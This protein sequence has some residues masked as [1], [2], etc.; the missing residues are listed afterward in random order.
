[1]SLDELFRRLP[2]VKHSTR[3][4]FFLPSGS[5]LRALSPQVIV[6][7]GLANEPRGNTFGN[8]IVTGTINRNLTNVR[9]I[10]NDGL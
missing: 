7:T 4:P 5:E 3:G 2:R 6:L 1:M 9:G 10:A 8:N